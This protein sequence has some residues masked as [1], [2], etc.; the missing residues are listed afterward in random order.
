MKILRLVMIFAFSSLL[1]FTAC[2]STDPND[3]SKQ[4][5]V[6]TTLSQLDA[7]L[8]GMADLQSSR[9]LMAAEQMPDGLIDLGIVLPKIVNSVTPHNLSKNS[10]SGRFFDTLADTTILD[11]LDS[12]AALYGTHS[13]ING[14]WVSTSDPASE[15]IIIMYPFTDLNV[16]S[17]HEAKIRVH[18]ISLAET[19]IGGDLE[20]FI[21]NTRQMWVEL[22]VTGADLFSETGVPTFMGI[23]GGMLADNGITVTFSLEITNTSMIVEIGVAGLSSLTLTVAADGIFDTIISDGD[24]IPTSISMQYGEIELVVNN[25][26]VVNPGDDMGD[27]LYSG[28]KVGDIVIEETGIFIVFINGEKANLAELLPNAFG[29]L[30]GIPI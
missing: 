16:G 26:D 29:L 17:T 18:S 13:Y 23:S 5:E 28:I 2:D 3:D 27:V 10:L 25:F 12:L 30:E 15:E 7:T 19:A 8:G 24:L 11:L 21:D 22:D 6:E 1:V 4:T 20:I 14:E 9:L